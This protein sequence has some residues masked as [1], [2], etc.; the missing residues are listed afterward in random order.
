MVCI[1]EDERNIEKG[2]E[3]IQVYV[4]LRGTEFNNVRDKGNA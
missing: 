1:L 3:D 2:L 4:Q